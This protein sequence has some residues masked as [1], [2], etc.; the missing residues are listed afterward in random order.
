MEQWKEFRTGYSISNYGRVRN[1]KT[2]AFRLL[3]DRDKRKLGYL[4]THIVDKNYSIHRLVA[5]YFVANLKPE[6]FDTVNHLD[7]DPSNNRWDNLEWCTQKLNVKHCKDQGR[8]TADNCENFKKQKNEKGKPTKVVR[9]KKEALPIG[10]FA[11][12]SKNGTRFHARFSNS[13]TGYVGL[14][15]YSTV[16]EAFQAVKAKYFSEY[17]VYPDCIEP[18]YEE[19]KPFQNAK[20]KLTEKEVLEIRALSLKNTEIAFMY[21][22]SRQNVNDIKKRRTWNHI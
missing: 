12:K 7:N 10:V 19:P 9:A 16:Y 8:H 20:T 22:I 11:V 3:Q 14:G 1:D 13:V 21:G 17:G 5:T 6:E 18:E 2:G 15:T 4:S